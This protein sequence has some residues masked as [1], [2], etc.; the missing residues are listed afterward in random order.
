M[1]RRI[2][3]L[4]LIVWLLGLVWFVV[5]LPQP[6]G[7]T[8]TDGVVVVTGGAGRIERGISVL[9]DG[10]AKRMLVSG[11]D[12]SVRASELAEVQNVPLRDRKSVV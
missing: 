12:P 8:R 3:S 5:S 6:S 11:V 4:F 7:R 1:I 9:Q 2:V 10:L